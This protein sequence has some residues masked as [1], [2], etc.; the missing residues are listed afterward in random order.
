MRFHFFA[1]RDTELVES[2][3]YRGKESLISRYFSC[4]RMPS[5]TLSGSVI[6]KYGT[7]NTSFGSWRAPNAKPRRSPGQ[8]LIDRGFRIAGRISPTSIFLQEF[9]ANIARELLSEKTASDAY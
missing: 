2:R 3:A 6:G 1:N 5:R 8:F 9:S 4:G 7:S